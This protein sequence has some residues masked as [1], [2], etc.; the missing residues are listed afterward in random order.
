MSDE[1]RSGE[2]PTDR[3]SPVGDPVVRG[4]VTDGEQPVQFD[5]DDQESLDAAA[6]L[7]GSFADTDPDDA[8]HLSMLR[9]A[10]A[11]AVLVRGMG[12]Y[13]AAAER[14]GEDVTVS[15]I[16]TWA[17]VHD[18][19]QAVRRHVATGDIA[20]STAKHIARLQG[21][22]RLH[23]AWAVIDHDLS[24]RE[25]RDVVGDVHDGN[26]LDAA[27]EQRGYTLGEMTVTLP[28]RTYCLLRQEASRNGQTPGDTIA[29]LFRKS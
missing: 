23:L 21:T 7:V 15:F 12:S 29:E 18:L 27:L 2:V 1:Q 24:V 16:R 13:R 26:S 25:V 19:P 8:T 20:P 22:P 17:R 10:A 6:E 14:A 11:C 9:G 5:P 3:N 28:N 4:E